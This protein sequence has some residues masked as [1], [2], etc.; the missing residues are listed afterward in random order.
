M[1]RRIIT[2]LFFA[3][4]SCISQAAELKIGL[5]SA[6]TSMDP[7]FHNI[8]S[9]N[10]MSRHVFET[11]VEQDPKQQLQP[12]L[13][14][15]WRS[16][17]PTT[18]EVKLRE[19]VKWHDGSPFTAQDVEF[20]I[21]RAAN[22]PNSPSSFGFVTKTIK[23]VKVVGPHLIQ[24]IT[25]GPNALLAKELS[26][27]PIVSK[28]VGESASTE[29]YN[30]G[31]AMIGTGPYKFVEYVPNT[32][33]VLAKNPDYWG[34]KE[35][36]EKVTFKFLTQPVSRVAAFVSKD[37]D[38]IESVP[39]TEVARL[40]ADSNF[41]VVE[42]LS[43]RLIFMH[44]DS[45]RDKSPFVRDKSGAPM[46]KNP[47]KDER[48]RKAMS[49]AIDRQA[50]ITNQLDGRGVATAQ[51]MPDGA[52]GSSKK[53]L[54][55]KVDIDGAKKLLAEAGYPN[56]FGLTLHSPLNRYVNDAQIAVVLGQMLSK[57]GI[58]AKV[59]VVPASVYFGRASKLE[60]SSMLLGWGGADVMETAG[61]LRALLMTYN[62]DKGEGAANRGRYSN[63]ALDKVVNEALDTFNDAKRAEVSAK[64]VETAMAST[65]LIPLYFEMGTWALRKDLEYRPR[66]TQ[67]TLAMDVHPSH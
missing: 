65:A 67:Y 39:P 50:I 38:V 9:N 1:K 41:K 49:K 64:A 43:N 23:E 13:A 8:S 53:L 16:V 56:G 26:L 19:N 18:W 2:A 22:V 52:F 66:I 46:D 14:V 44:L 21:K 30:S 59:E 20:S 10:S 17:N 34:A 33:V 11:L 27:L 47:L 54:P 35:G 25:D 3:V 51:V 63:P 12:C 7:H 4:A 45:D 32:R 57:I 31:K 62:K 61:V 24:L 28:K 6:V 58:D 15:S 37:V 55:E 5:Q 48:V 36:W 42:G 29:D 40:K 60:F